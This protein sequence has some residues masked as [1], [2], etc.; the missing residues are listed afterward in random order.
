MIV[1]NERQLGTVVSLRNDPA[2]KNEPSAPA[3]KATPSRTADRVE[4]SGHREEVEQLKKTME[5]TAPD[6]SDRVASLK[7]QIEAGTYRVDARE[8]AAKMLK[9]WRDIHEK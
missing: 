8:V 9:N 5:G 6:A 7:A 3:G 1:N 2:E 4:L